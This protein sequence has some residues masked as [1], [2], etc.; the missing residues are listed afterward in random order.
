MARGDPDEAL[1][2]AASLERLRAVPGFCLHARETIRKPPAMLARG[3][4]E[5]LGELTRLLSGIQDRFSARWSQN[6][7]D[8]DGL[9]AEARAAL[10]ELRAALDD[11]IVPDPDPYAGAIGEAEA[12]RR[13]HYEHASIHNAG[14]VWRAALR[15][16]GEVEAEVVALAR[17]LDP[18][19][20]W[21]EVYR[22]VRGSTLPAAEMEG[23]F[24]RWRTRARAFAITRGLV[25]P[26]EPAPLDVERVHDPERRAMVWAEYR[27]SEAGLGR[28]VLGEVPS[29]CLPW[30]AVRFGEPGLHFHA[31]LTRDL[32]ALVRRHIGSSSTT[33]GFGLYIQELMAE[34]GFCPEPAARLVARVLVLRQVAL[35]LVDIGV[36]T[37]QL[38][39]EE[40]MAYL[41]ERLPFDRTL[42]LGDVRRVLA[43]PLTGCAA[44]L[45]WQE[46]R[47]LRDD[48]RA[49]RGS[50]DPADFHRRLFGFGGI[51]IPLIRWGMGLDA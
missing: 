22:S 24:D 49:A 21:Q 1:E 12:D 43:D 44:L 5:Q 31:S 9:V 4:R 10:D 14:E 34:Q 15:S 46:L 37:R 2:A 30:I 51:P 8:A 27:M 7:A 29:A 3:A 39:T 32:P 26:A 25:P 20:S 33:G 45:G 48:D 6:G 38:T 36:H 41:S 35:A 11:E 18:H 47:R 50:S 16:T 19:D 28:V 40:A 23:E 42:A 13:L 17:E